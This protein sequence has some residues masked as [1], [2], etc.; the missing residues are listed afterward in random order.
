[1]HHTLKLLHWLQLHQRLFLKSILTTVQFLGRQG[2]AL[3]GRYYKAGEE[4]SA[5]GELDSNFI[6]VE[7]RRKSLAS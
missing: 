5:S 2:I 4:S 7:I 6:E 1:M 3:R